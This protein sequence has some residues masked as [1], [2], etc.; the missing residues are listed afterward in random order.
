MKIEVTKKFLIDCIVHRQPS[1]PELFDY[2]PSFSPYFREGAGG[3]KLW[4]PVK[5]ESLNCKEL[6]AV[7]TKTRLTYELDFPCV[8]GIVVE[9]Q[10]DKIETFFNNNM[11][12][13]DND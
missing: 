5:L 10:R 12:I 11:G 8:Y 2:H 7:Y 3:L 1:M 13:F 9:D 4:E 6:L